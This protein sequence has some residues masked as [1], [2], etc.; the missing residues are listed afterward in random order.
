MGVTI[1]PGTLRG[2]VQAIP[3]SKAACAHWIAA[4]LSDRQTSL[5]MSS[6]LPGLSSVPRCLRKL[7]AGMEWMDASWK[8]H[9]TQARVPGPV[10]LYCGDCGHALRFLLP[11]VAA[12]GTSAIIEA[13]GWLSRRFA[14]GYLQQLREHGVMVYGN[15]PPLSL[16]GCLQ[17]GIF[18]LPGNTHPDLVS[19]LLMALPLTGARSEV[20]F[21]STLERREDVELTVSILRKYDIEINALPDGYEIPGSQRYQSGGDMWIEGDWAIA[22]NYLAA[23]A[24]GSQIR[25]SGLLQDS[26]QGDRRSVELLGRLYAGGRGGLLVD[27]MDVP[28]LFPILAVAATQAPNTL[29]FTNMSWLRRQEGE[30][31][32]S[33]RECLSTLGAHVE[34]MPD[35]LTVHGGRPLLGGELSVKGDGRVAMAMAMAA[36]VADAPVTIRNIDAAAAAYPGFIADLVALGAQ[37]EGAQWTLRKDAPQPVMG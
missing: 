16:R 19:G 26:A 15:A 29:T 13:D 25:I 36:L 9:P 12:L 31:V 30:M 11:V 18:T 27:A 22:S 5:A 35:G 34:E 17:G 23:N 1:H 28:D 10:H 7:G 2:Q 37:V 14:G 33:L 21:S 3:S 4:A 32:Y 20:R 24:M 8:V 6:P